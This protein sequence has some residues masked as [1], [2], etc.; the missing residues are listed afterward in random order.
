VF[1][2]HDNFAINWF[3]PAAPEPGTM[4]SDVYRSFQLFPGVHVNQQQD[5]MLLGQCRPLSPR[6]LV[7]HVDFLADRSAP[8][9]R[10]DHFVE[11]WSRTYAEDGR[12]LERQQANIDAGVVDALR[13]VDAAEPQ[14][15][16]YNRLIL[17]RYWAS[18][19]PDKSHR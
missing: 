10:V 3:P 11:L 12:A 6:R 8:R 13:Y 17:D 15:R 18:L 4:R 2:A 19:H 7:F 16:F 1:T 9:D 5:F 14:T